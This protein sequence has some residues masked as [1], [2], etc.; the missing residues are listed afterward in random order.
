[1]KTI[2]IHHFFTHDMRWEDNT[3]ISRAILHAGHLCDSKEDRI[4][5]TGWICLDP[6]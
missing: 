6:I 4:K 1:M 5:I 3:A 2:E